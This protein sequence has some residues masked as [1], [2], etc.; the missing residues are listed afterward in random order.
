MS[1]EPL[2]N[3]AVELTRRTFNYWNS[4]EVPPAIDR[5]T[6]PDGFVFEDRRSTINFGRVDASGWQEYLAASWNL[7]DEP[8]QRSISEVLAVRGQRCAAYGHVL[9]LRNG[10]VIESIYCLCLTPDLRGVQLVVQFDPVDVD[11]A[12]AELDRMHAEIA[13]EADTPS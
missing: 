4:L 6:T 3:A 7:G 2:T 8:P 1:D 11:A 13:D 10:S 5:A 9:D 12:I